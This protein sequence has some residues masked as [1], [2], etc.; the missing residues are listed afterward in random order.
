MILTMDGTYKLTAS[1]MLLVEGEFKGHLEY[2][3]FIAEVR[4]VM[5]KMF[6]ENR[7]DLVQQ[8]GSL[9]TWLRPRSSWRRSAPARKC[10]CPVPTHASSSC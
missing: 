6:I 3:T 5:K 4:G 1:P 2:V 10:H 7:A 9:S 8:L